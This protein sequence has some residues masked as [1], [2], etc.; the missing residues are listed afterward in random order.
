[1]NAIKEISYQNNNYCTR[2]HL[3]DYLRNNKINF[4]SLDGILDY[5][6]NDGYLIDE[7]EVLKITGNY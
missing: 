2:K 6:L 7:D 3:F 5:L 1:L 4:S